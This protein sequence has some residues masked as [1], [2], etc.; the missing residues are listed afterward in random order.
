MVVRRHRPEKSIPAARVG[1]NEDVVAGVLAERCPDLPHVGVHEPLS[2]DES[3]RPEGV[4]QRVPGDDLARIVCQQ[5]EKP[6]RHRSQ[7]DPFAGTRKLE[8][9]P[10]DLPVVESHVHTRHT[11]RT[12]SDCL[13]G[14]V[15]L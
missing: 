4:I 12:A 8:R 15:P 5:E 11:G 3:V 7:F 6:D 14:I 9:L 13:L 1:P 10:V 2:I